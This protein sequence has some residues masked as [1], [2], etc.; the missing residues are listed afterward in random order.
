MS[1]PQKTP[2]EL[3]EQID[4]TREEL[5]V[6]VQQLAAK[7]AVKARLRRRVEHGKKTAKDAV[8]QAKANLEPGPARAVVIGVGTIVLLGAWTATSASQGDHRPAS[9]RPERRRAGA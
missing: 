7:T 1:T 3:R 2:K 9:A 4:A 6:T 5:G 8:H